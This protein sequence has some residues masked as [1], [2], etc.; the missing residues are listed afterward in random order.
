M[1]FMIVVSGQFVVWTCVIATLVVLGVMV[2][3]SLF[4]ARGLASS[5]C[6]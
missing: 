5:V 4:E 3:S 6:R 2:I 1:W